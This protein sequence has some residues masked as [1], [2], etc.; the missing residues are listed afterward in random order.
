MDKSELK[1]IGE[2]IEDAMREVGVLLIAFAPLDV[3]LNHHQAGDLNF[4]LLFLGLGAA[5]FTGA[6]LLEGRRGKDPLS[7]SRT[8]LIF[9]ALG[10]ILMIAALL[11]GLR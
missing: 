4:L 11:M 8:L 6:L 5:L 2:R 10:A 3:A 9:L 7:N 1:T